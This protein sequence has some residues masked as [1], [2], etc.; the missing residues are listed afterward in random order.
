LRA[1]QERSG[2]RDARLRGGECGR[3]LLECHGTVA[4]P[5]F[6]IGVEAKS[7]LLLDI[8]ISFHEK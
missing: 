1:F 6:T 2:R 8:M 5:K 3:R 7:A 4:V